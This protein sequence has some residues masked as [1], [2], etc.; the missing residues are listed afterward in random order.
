MKQIP[1][2]IARKGRAIGLYGIDGEL[3]VAMATPED[4]ALL[5]RLRQIALHGGAVDRRHPVAATGR[6]HLRQMQGGLLLPSPPRAVL[7]RHFTEEG[8]SEVPF[9][10]GRGCPH[11]RDTGYRGRVAFHARVVITEEIRQMISDR[12]SVQEITRAATKGGYRPPP[13]AGLNKVL[14]GLTTIEEIEENCSF[15]PAG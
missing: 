2:E 3:T 1:L 6:A 10:R 13:Y 15:E 12:K 7:L 14:L 5:L 9:F 4:V 8:L 11:C